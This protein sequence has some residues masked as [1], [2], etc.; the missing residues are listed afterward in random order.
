MLS[1][2]TSD[3][4]SAESVWPVSSKIISVNTEKTLVVIHYT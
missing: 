1:E 3:I 4:D 2:N